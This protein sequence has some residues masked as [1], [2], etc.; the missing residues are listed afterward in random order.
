VRRAGPRSAWSNVGLVVVIGVLVTAGLAV[1][2]ATVH[3]NNEHR[4]LHERVDEARAVLG[5]AIPAID[6]SLG[7]PAAVAAA[8]GGS[9][10]AFDDVVRPGI[11]LGSP[12]DAVSL[13]RLGADGPQPI[14]GAG[15]RRPMP[16][17]RMEAVAARAV[18]AT[19]FV[20]VDLLAATPRR[21]GYAL[22]W[23]QPHPRYL[24]Y[25]ERSLPRTRR[26]KVARDSAFS[27]LDYALF[28]GR[29]AQ[30]GELV[31]SSTGG[32]RLTGRTGA[33]TVRFGDTRLLLVVSPRKE[34][35][36]TLLAWLPT[37]ITVFL[38]LCT[39]AAAFTVWRLSKRRDEAE[40]L[41]FENERLYADQRGVA[42]T[43]QHSLLPQR[44][45]DA[46]GLEF[47]AIYAPGTEGIDIG[48]DWYEVVPRADGT[49]VVVV[50]DVSGH[51]LDAATMM[52]SLRF[53]I[54]A[55]AADGDGP[56]T[57]LDKLARLVNV[58]RDGHFATVLCG[59]VDPA[60][61]TATWA[62]AGHLRPL[63]VADGRRRFLPVPVGPPVGVGTG[64]EYAEQQGD[65]PASG[66]LLLY[67]DGLIERRDESIDV[68]FDRLAHAAGQADAEPLAD[69]LFTVVRHTIPD[70]C[71]D[72][73]ALLGIRW[74]RAAGAGSSGAAPA[75]RAFP[76][77][78]AAVTDA[79]LHVIRALDG[80]PDDVVETV[81]LLVSELA[82]NSVRHA[83]D[84]F[85]VTVEPGPARIRVAVADRGPGHPRTR[86]PGPV[87]TSGRGLVIV[88]ALSDAWGVDPAPDGVGKTV[89]FEIA[90]AH[91][92]A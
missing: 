38:L 5:A 52:A 7:S 1:G 60:A 36:G 78:P 14:T 67:T 68:G 10:A 42:Q 73:A 46:P 72:D 35:G 29:R 50:G 65:L 21:L 64:V 12:F 33:V 32:A 57:I 31:A 15:A 86:S 61:G 90:T 20:V 16:A 6:A 24:V 77:P 59:V 13:W 88:E 56:A 76:A 84:G 19:G 63:L 89:W 18:R 34:L 8:T 3:D 85:T 37:V 44:L 83:R 26:A 41:A 11:A 79:R 27:D 48:G 66:T 23:P 80:A 40:R 53:A 74:H 4:L 25:G 70:G 55:Y 75:S 91:A 58:G 17:A 92:P 71:D 81:A 87:E 62:D 30:P 49:V 47:S 39:A 43:L 2:A 69:A 22:A 51:G 54:R 28:V 45:P 9:A 82:T